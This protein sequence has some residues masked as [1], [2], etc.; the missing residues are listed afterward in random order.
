VV[1]HESPDEI[2]REMRGC[3]KMEFDGGVEVWDGR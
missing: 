2:A 3:V 1:V